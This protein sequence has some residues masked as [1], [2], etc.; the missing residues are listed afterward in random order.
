MRRALVWPERGC[1]PVPDQRASS[2]ANTLGFCLLFILYV[3]FAGAEWRPKN[4]VSPGRVA[5]ARGSP[6]KRTPP[7]PVGGPINRRCGIK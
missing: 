1:I 5:G 3:S 2:N 6:G 7:A 4:A